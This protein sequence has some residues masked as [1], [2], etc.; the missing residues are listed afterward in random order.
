MVRFRGI[1]KEHLES[2]GYNGFIYDSMVEVNV[3][4]LLPLSSVL[5]NVICDYCGNAFETSYRNITNLKNSSIGLASCKDCKHLRCQ[6]IKRKSTLE[7]CNI[8]PLYWDKNWLEQQYI[9]NNMSAKEIGK[10]CRVNTRRIMRYVDRFNLVKLRDPNT[11]LTKEF[12]ENE[13]V[14]NMKSIFQVSKENRFSTQ[15]VKNML[16]RY[17]IHIRTASEYMSNYY[18]LKGGRKVRSAKAEVIW[19][20][21]DFRNKHLEATRN[22]FTYDLRKKM[23][24]QK[25]GIPE[26]E[27]NGFLTNR[28]VLARGSFEYREW[29]AAV[30]LRDNYTCQC[31]GARSSKNNPVILHVHHIENY[32]SNPELRL[33]VDNGITMCNHCHSPQ[34]LGSFHSI[35]GNRNNSKEQ[36][37][38]YIKNNRSE[39]ISADVVQVFLNQM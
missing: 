6:E 30:F 28:N 8:D 4:D 34:Q 19:K 35:Y 32:S 31:C 12:L 7:S 21:D 27:W 20:S 29:R 23:S 10:L 15:T 16:I 24:A 5:V 17:D 22:A 3:I 38:E 25:Q 36:L 13:Y 18:D 9:I 11:I 14:K 33:C 37:E 26:E 39:I 2:I 1:Q